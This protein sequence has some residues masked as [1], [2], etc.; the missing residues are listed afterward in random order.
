MLAEERDERAPLEP[1][2][3]ADVGEAEQVQENVDELGVHVRLLFYAAC[4]C[5]VCVLR[6]WVV[7]LCVLCWDSV[8]QSAVRSTF[9]VSGDDMKEEKQRG[10][11]E[12]DLCGDVDGAVGM[13]VKYS[14]GK[15]E[16]SDGGVECN[17]VCCG[18]KC[19]VHAFGVG[20]L[21]MCLV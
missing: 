13:R 12:E 18:E 6:V 5:V 20:G 15:R 4:G 14:V 9:S 2:C 7:C 19:C 1:A 17:D 16:Q 8:V 3:D 10:K 21:Y 11:K